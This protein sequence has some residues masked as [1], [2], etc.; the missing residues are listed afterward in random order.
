MVKTVPYIQLPRQPRDGRYHRL[1]VL[2]VQTVPYSQLL[3]QPRDGR[4]L[5]MVRLGFL[6]VQTVPYIARFCFE[7]LLNKSHTQ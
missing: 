3:R 2:L 1:V 7:A 4:Y 6:L 5:D